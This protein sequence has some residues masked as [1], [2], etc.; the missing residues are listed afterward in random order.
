MNLKSTVPYVLAALLC[1]APSAAQTLVGI[2]NGPNPALP[3]DP[4][5]KDHANFTVST[6]DY[7]RGRA[8]YFAS[9]NN[10]ILVNFR[11]SDGSWE[12]NPS[13]VAIEFPP[14]MA[15]PEVTIALGTV[16]ASATNDFYNAWDRLSY[17][18]LMY[19]IWQ[20]KNSGAGQVCAAFSNDGVTWVQPTI[21]IGKPGT[22]LTRCESG[23]NTLKLE[24]IAGSR[25]GS[26][27][28]LAGLEGDIS[29]LSQQVGTGRTLTYL[30]EANVAS[31]HV[32]NIR[33]EFPSAGM[34]MP[35]IAGGTRD[36]FFRDLDFTYDQVTDKALLTR[37]TPYPYNVNGTAGDIPCSGSCTRGFAAY[38]M[39]GQIY[40][41]RVNGNVL[42]LLNGVWTLE[43]DI[44]R[45]TGW[46][47][48]QGSICKPYPANRSLQTPI[49]V[50][51]DSVC[52][53]KTTNGF[54]DREN[55]NALTLYLSGYTNRQQSCNVQTQPFGSFL[56]GEQYTLD[57]P[58]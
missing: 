37:A 29:L 1:S 24:A 48:F 17:K 5:N 52:I 4:L 49:G 6:F 32:L 33:G 27:L 11:K 36:Y 54:V 2:P 46:S 42:G 41:Q 35:T 22:P 25:S 51:M 47:A 19:F 50:D 18:R 55:P 10:R 39:R 26:T 21:R 15:E 40:S 34:Y 53:H 58:F 28:W 8:F 31:P 13:R 3:G 14:T 12:F 45:S 20:G 43:A 9:Q 16:L 30:I 44:G 38:P 23:G 7:W 57:W 56:D